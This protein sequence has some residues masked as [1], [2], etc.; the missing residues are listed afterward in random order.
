MVQLPRESLKMPMINP[1]LGQS[2]QQ[3]VVYDANTGTSRIQTSVVA[4]PGL[5]RSLYDEIRM[6]PGFGTPFVDSY[7]DEGFFETGLPS[8][9]GSTIGNSSIAQPG[10]AGSQ[11]VN[12]GIVDPNLAQ[13]GINTYN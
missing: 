1:N 12:S 4:T 8:K 10:M 3:S 6:R 2:V 5:K 9:L 7:G 13:S 11:L